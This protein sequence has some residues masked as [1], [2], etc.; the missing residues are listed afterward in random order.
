[1]EDQGAECGH[2]HPATDADADEGTDGDPDTDGHSHAHSLA[3][4]WDANAAPRPAVRRGRSN[5]GD[6]LAVKAEARPPGR[7]GTRVEYGRLDKMTVGF[8]F[9]L[10]H[11]LME[12]VQ[13]AAERRGITAHR[14]IRL[15]AERHHQDAAPP[16]LPRKSVKSNVSVP[17]WVL[18]GLDAKAAELGTT[19]SDIV[20]A[21]IERELENT[22]KAG[23]VA[24]GCS[25]E[26]ARA[27][28]GHALHRVPEGG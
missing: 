12:R 11:D 28:A 10:P 21:A 26:D 6:P 17:G 2:H 25:A 27:G 18:D 22:G 5:D 4:L 3:A 24:G 1:M 14:F 8:S 9:S 7:D 15:A 13:E 23:D 20:R 19:R 16:P